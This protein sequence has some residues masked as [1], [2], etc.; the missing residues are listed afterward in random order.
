M[1]THTAPFVIEKV[2]KALGSEGVVN[3]TPSEDNKIGQSGVHTFIDDIMNVI[4]LNSVHGFAEPNEYATV[5]KALNKLFLEQTI[6]K[7]DQQG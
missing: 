5:Y 6:V 1:K 7:I 4:V 2:T 3:H